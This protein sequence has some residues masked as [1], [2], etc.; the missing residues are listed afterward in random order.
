MPPK[1]SR[2][3]S[4]SRNAPRKRRARKRADSDASPPIAVSTTGPSLSQQA[5]TASHRVSTLVSQAKLPKHRVVI[6]GYSAT[7]NKMNPNQKTPTTLTRDVSAT[8]ELLFQDSKEA[9]RYMRAKQVPVNS[10]WARPKLVATPTGYTVQNLVKYEI[11][12]HVPL[13]TSP[14]NHAML[15]IDHDFSLRLIDLMDDVEERFPAKKELAELDTGWHNTT[16]FQFLTGN[17]ITVSDEVQSSPRDHWRAMIAVG[18]CDGWALEVPSIGLTVPLTPGC[19]IFL[20]STGFSFYLINHNEAEVDTEPD[21]DLS[22][23]E[24][25]EVDEEENA[26]SD[27][28]DQ[29]SGAGAGDQASDAGEDDRML[30]GV[31]DAAGSDEDAAGSDEDAAGSDEDAAGSDEDA[32]GSD[33]DAA[34]EGDDTGGE[35]KDAQGEINGATGE[36]EEALGGLE[37]AAGKAE[38]TVE[39]ADNVALPLVGNN[40]DVLQEPRA[41]IISSYTEKWLWDMMAQQ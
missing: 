29:M 40:Q 10:E 27:D 33:E 30:G 3:P 21:D 34:G 22:E 18:D 12:P 15:A 14:I 28:G 11:L 41:F 4:S 1:R 38:H 37:D 26:P 7:T 31:E 5:T 9:L 35:A 23:D 32:A 8:V 24:S 20:K 25:G 39:E 13:A 16:S 19:A 6:R 17:K 36:A 2:Q